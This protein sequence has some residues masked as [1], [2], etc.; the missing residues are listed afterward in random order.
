MTTLTPFL[1][2]SEPISSWSHLLAAVVFLVIGIK[3]IFKGRGNNTRMTSLILYV[4]SGVFLFAMSGVYHLLEK[5]TDANYVLQILDHAGIYLLIAGSFTPFQ[6]I[7]LR[8]YQRWIP[9]TL[10]WILA[11]T[12]LTLTSIFFSDMPEWLILCFFLGMGW[13]SLFTVWFLRKIS[14]ETI[15]YIAIGGVFYTVGAVCDFLKWP[16]LA[17]SIFGPHEFFHICV[18]LGALSHFYGIYKIATRPISTELTLIIKKFPHK[19]FGKIHSEMAQ[20]SGETD[21][22]IKKQ[23]KSWIKAEYHEEHIPR[24][25]KIKYFKEEHIDSWD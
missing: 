1:G 13:M 15:K 4:F 16:I 14:I 19:Y 24:K 5:G 7:L 10:I 21:T 3:M 20:F 18:V 22:C 9:L 11:I 6:I 8:G 25:L 23:V 12:G 2:F 17:D